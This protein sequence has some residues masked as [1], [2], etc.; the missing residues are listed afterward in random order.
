MARRT[1]VIVL[2]Q[3]RAH[4]LTWDNF[5]ENVLDQLDADL[6]VCVPAD[7]FFDPTNLFYI[8]ARFRWLVP[9]APDLAEVFDQIQKQ[10]GSSEQWR[11]LCEVKGS[12]LGRIAESGQPG[13]AAILFI[14]R[15]FMLNNLRAEGLDKIYDRFVITRSDFF[16]VC[17]HPPLEC[18]AADNLWIPDGEDY[19]GL[20]DRHLVVSAADLIASCNLIDDLLLRPRQMRDAMIEN[21]N[22][23]I[24]QVIALHLTRNGLISKVRRFPYIMFIVR[25]SGDPSAWSTGDYESDVDMVVKYPTELHE[26]SRYQHLLRSIDDWRLYFSSRCLENSLPARIYTFQG[27]ILYIDEKT[28]QLRHG[29]LRGSPDNVFYVGSKLSGR[30][31]HCPSDPVRGAVIPSDHTNSSLVHSANGARSVAVCE[32]ERVPTARKMLRGGPGCLVGLKSGSLHL[33][34]EPDGRLVLDRPHLFE[35]EQFRLVPD[36]HRKTNLPQHL[37]PVHMF[38]HKS[39]PIVRAG[40]RASPEAKPENRKLTLSVFE[41]GISGW[42]RLKIDSPKGLLGRD[43]SEA[44]ESP[45]AISHRLQSPSADPLYNGY[46]FISSHLFVSS[47]FEVVESLFGLNPQQV[48]YL[49]INLRPITLLE[50][51]WRSL[52]RGFFQRPGRFLQYYFRPAGSFL[53]RSEFPCPPLE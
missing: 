19:G 29:P 41:N 6:A 11:V 39:R 27:T 25:D 12:W 21:S 45:S 2:G 5:K 13:A 47:K 48:R 9:D 37:S 34:S 31:V 52:R 4:Q 42:Y 20:C 24:E 35:R 23:N 50:Y 22:W 43:T 10:L 14:L 3:L 28:G 33:C 49:V 44:I 8:N 32:V 51:F 18:L 1:L 26:A 30:I 38:R 15:W 16:Y 36:F 53:L 46:L 7:A 40:I 17:P